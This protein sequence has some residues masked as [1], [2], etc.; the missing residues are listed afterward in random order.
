M[1]T[2]LV[3]DSSVV[4]K[5]L[6]TKN[7]KYLNQANQIMADAQSGTVILLAPELVKY[8]VGNALLLS[9]RLSP[10]NSRII[11]KTLYS[12]QI[13]FVPDSEELAIET[14]RIAQN[15][16]ITYYDASFVALAKR[17]KAALVTDNPKH[18]GKHLDVQVIPL[19]EY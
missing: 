12:L 6:H 4:V 16:G 9:K 1:P 18:Q 19:K 7:E 3:V 5:W 13:Q 8:E 14:Y 11:L 2:P 10:E 15:L 17:E